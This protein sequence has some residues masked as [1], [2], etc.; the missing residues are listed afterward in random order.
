MRD[1]YGFADNVYAWLGENECERVYKVMDLACQMGLPSDETQEVED[2]FARYD[3]Y[4]P[5]E[6]EKFW[7]RITERS[8]GEA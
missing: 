1:I 7:A 6:S 8:Q 4:D 3:S 2:F 5:E